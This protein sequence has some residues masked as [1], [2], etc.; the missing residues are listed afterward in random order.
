LRPYLKKYLNQKKKK[1]KR[2][3]GVA[4]ELLPSKCEAMSSNPSTTI[5]HTHITSLI[6]PGAWLEV[7]KKHQDWEKQKV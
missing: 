7:E 6:M 1:K 4:Q 3:G 5:K 2:A